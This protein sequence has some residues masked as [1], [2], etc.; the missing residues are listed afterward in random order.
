MPRFFID[1]DDG[2]QFDRDEDGY[3]LPDRDAARVEA[4][5]AL[6]D[7]ARSQIPDGDRRTFRVRVRDADGKPVYE[8]SLTLDGRWLEPEAEEG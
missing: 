2:D 7:L 5:G 4:I 8:A 3:E 6:P 1:T